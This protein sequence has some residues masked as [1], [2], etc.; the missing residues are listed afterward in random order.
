ML[1]HAKGGFCETKPIWQTFS[2]LQ[3][4]ESNPIK[5]DQTV[6]VVQFQESVVA[7]VYDRRFG[8]SA[9]P[10][11]HHAPGVASGASTTAVWMWF[12]LS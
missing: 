2:A 3:K 7:A 1:T 9:C 8:L 11:L 12:R 10:A 5:P 6:V 4:T